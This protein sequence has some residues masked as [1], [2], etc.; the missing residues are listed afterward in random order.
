VPLRRGFGALFIKTPI[1]FAFHNERWLIHT[2][3]HERSNESRFHVRGYMDR[4]ATTT[5]CDMVVLKENVPLPSSHRR[6]LSHPTPTVRSVV[7]HRHFQSQAVQHHNYIRQ[8]FEDT[9]EVRN[10]RRTADLSK[11]SATPPLAK[12]HP[13]ANMFSDSCFH[14]GA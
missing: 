4:G 10:W 12:G 5:A 11:Q 2:M 13:R 14:D 8:H 3:V 9:P 6:V 7:R 1:V